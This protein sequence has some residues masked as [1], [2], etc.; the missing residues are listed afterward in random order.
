MKSRK[1]IE[2][3]ARIDKNVTSYLNENTLFLIEENKKLKQQG[4]IDSVY[5]IDLMD[6]MELKELK[7]LL[8]RYHIC[9]SIETE[10]HFRIPEQKCKN[11]TKKLV[12][13][14]QQ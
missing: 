6:K 10:Q 11:K 7:K 12:K 4:T 9:E 2:E 13:E 3:L 1:N 5:N 14:E 8:L